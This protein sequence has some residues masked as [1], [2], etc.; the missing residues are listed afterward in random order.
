MAKQVAQQD[1]EKTQ[2]QPAKSPNICKKKK[3]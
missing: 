2:Q 1:E 3:P